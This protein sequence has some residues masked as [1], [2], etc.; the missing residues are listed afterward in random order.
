MVA[1]IKGSCWEQGRSYSVTHSNPDT[2]AL[3]DM[4]V[5]VVHGKTLPERIDSL[6]LTITTLTPDST[7]YS[8]SWVIYPRAEEGRTAAWQETEQLYRSRIRFAMEGDYVF[9]F[10]HTLPEDIDGITAIGI[11]I[12]R[13]N[14]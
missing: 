4:S 7:T 8:E 10:S 2:L 1:D 9:T 6:P 13:S 3:Y 11:E 5:F 12:T 14:R